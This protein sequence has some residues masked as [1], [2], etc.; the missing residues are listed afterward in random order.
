MRRLNPASTLRPV[1]A[2]ISSSVGARAIEGVCFVDE[3][4]EKKASSEFPVLGA[5]SNVSLGTLDPTLPVG[6][7][8]VADGASLIADV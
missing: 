4:P 5:G 8:L 2:L 3:S 7:S 6:V 1:V